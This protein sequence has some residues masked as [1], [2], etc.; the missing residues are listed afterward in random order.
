M[1]ASTKLLLFFAIWL[2]T[3]IEANI[4][5]RTRDIDLNRSSNL[6]ISSIL[7]PISSP[8]SK[9]T[10]EPSEVE[11]LSKE[12]SLETETQKAD[13]E[14]E[15]E[16]SRKLVTVTKPERITRALKVL[17]PRVQMIRKRKYIVR[18]APQKNL[19]TTRMTKQL[20]AR[21]IKLNKRFR[22]TSKFYPTVN[23]KSL[24]MKIR[25]LQTTQMQTLNQGIRVSPIVYDD[26]D[27]LRNI[28]NAIENIYKYYYQIL[29]N[30]TNSTNPSNPNESEHEHTLTVMSFYSRIRSFVHTVVYNREKLFRDLNYFKAKTD[31][32]SSTEQEMLRFYGYQFKYYQLKSDSNAYMTTDGDLINQQFDIGKKINAEFDIDVKNILAGAFDLAR[33]NEYFQTE[34]NALAAVGYQDRL[35]NA[36]DKF[37]KVVMFVVRLVEIKMDIQKSMAETE[38][39]LLNC[40]TYRMD[41]EKAMM[42]VQKVIDTRKLEKT[43]LANSEFAFPL[44]ASLFLVVFFLFA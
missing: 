44:F 31:T 3:G 24:Q 40:K 10:Q 28:L 2:P 29:P 1:K 30:Q 25:K 39:S 11:T 23:R 8:L 13:S 7:D 4:F 22:R 15:T 32:L 20:P 43:R 18:R 9:D 42:T 16:P 12:T 27:T 5:S 19:S 26:I 41:I 21:S 34:I 14:Q 38:R 17:K 33:L 6:P 35:V 36:L 37:D